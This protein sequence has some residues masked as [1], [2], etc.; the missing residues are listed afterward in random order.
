M[1]EDEFIAQLSNPKTK[2]RAFAKLLDLYQERLYWQIRKIVGTHQDA[3]DVLQNTFL[4]VYKSITGFNKKSS[5][6]TWMYKIAYN[7]SV[8]LLEKRKR[9][10]AVSLDDLNSEYLQNFYSDEYFNGNDAQKKLVSILGN[11]PEKERNIF[12]LKYYDDL[13]FREIAEV[14]ELGESTIKTY[15]YNAVKYIENHIMNVSYANKINAL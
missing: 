1:I 12:Q 13:K 9:K 8:R 6:H 15:Y 11:L 14:L 4:R 7:E 2:E 3:D 10:T 5:L